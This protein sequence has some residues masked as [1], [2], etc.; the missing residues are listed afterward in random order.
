MRNR[1]RK[2]VEVIIGDNEGIIVG[3][4]VAKVTRNFAETQTA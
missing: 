4:D 1:S 3:D 2:E